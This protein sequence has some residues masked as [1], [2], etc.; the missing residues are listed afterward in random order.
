[1]ESLDCVNGVSIVS[2]NIGTVKLF[3]QMVL[4]LSWYPAK[5]V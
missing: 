5:R 3:D 2:M 4:M 1:M